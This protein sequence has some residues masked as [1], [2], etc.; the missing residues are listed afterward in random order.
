MSSTTTVNPSSTKLQNLIFY[1]LEI[2]PRYR[3]PQLQVAK[4]T[5][6]QF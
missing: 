5:Y 1:L 3:E 4:N 6:L 2:V